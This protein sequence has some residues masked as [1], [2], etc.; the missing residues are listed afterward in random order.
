MYVIIDRAMA[1]RPKVQSARYLN[2][3]EYHSKYS[4]L[5]YLKNERTYRYATYHIIMSRF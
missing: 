1:K 2:N 4:W 3:G 5:V